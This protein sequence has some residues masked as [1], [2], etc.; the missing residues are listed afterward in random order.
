M[1][2]SSDSSGQRGQHYGHGPKGWQRSDDRIRDDIAEKLA[3]HPDV[4]ASDIE[5]EVH[6]A[7]VTLKGN[8]DSRD[9]KRAAEDIAEGVFGVRDVQNQLRVSRGFWG[10]IKDTFTGDSSDDQ[11]DENRKDNSGQAQQHTTSDEVVSAGHS[12]S[13]THMITPQSGEPIGATTGANKNRETTTTPR[14]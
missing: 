13:P 4:D 12:G 1:G 10:T 6:N 14:K 5:V 7:E 11:R 9:S 2:Q 8:V 3:Q